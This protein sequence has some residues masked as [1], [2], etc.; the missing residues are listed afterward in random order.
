MVCWP[1]RS[2]Q[3][4][5]GGTT[6]FS[7]GG[8]GRFDGT[9]VNAPVWG[10]N[11]IEVVSSGFISTNYQIPNFPLSAFCVLRTTGSQIW[12][13][14]SPPI[15]GRQFEIASNQPLGTASFARYF[16]NRSS[17]SVPNVSGF[18]ATQTS[19]IG[20]RSNNYYVNGSALGSLGGVTGSGDWNSATNTIP[21]QICRVS[22]GFAVFPFLM[23]INADASQ[24]QANI[25][26]IYKQTLG[27]GL[28]LP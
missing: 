21:S 19:I 7:L 5:G 4:A 25:Y 3:N 15:E 6:A 26:T 27:L 18:W 9:L 16:S 17:I 12:Q 22:S 2:S 11:G 1:L 14:Q 10:A 23:A 8:L 28:G 24:S 20:N 13:L